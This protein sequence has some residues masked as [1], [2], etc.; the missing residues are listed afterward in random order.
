MKARI[1]IGKL[2]LAFVLV[3]VGFALGKEYARHGSTRADQGNAAAS[4]EAAA[5]GDRVVVYYLH[6][7]IRCVTCNA[8]EQAAADVVRT[9]FA[10]AVAAGRM[11]F[12]TANFE[13]DEALARRYDVVTS[14]IVLV[15]VKDGREAGHRRLEE[16]WTVVHDPE[17]L[18]EFLRTAF[19]ATLAGDTPPA[20]AGGTP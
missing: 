13:D 10:D 14:G 2:L 9:D 3:T 18:R 8:L 7:T 17:A 20:G 4:P 19:R 5:T 15:R 1:L 16:A 11:E 6:K 12:R